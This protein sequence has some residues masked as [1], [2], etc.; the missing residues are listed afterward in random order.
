[1]LVELPSADEFTDNIVAFWRP[2]ATLVPGAGNEFAYKLDLGHGRG[3]GTAA[4]A[5]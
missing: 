1:M 3:R 2:G 4:G 5:R